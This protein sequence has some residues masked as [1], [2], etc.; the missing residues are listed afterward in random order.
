MS[1]SYPL[2]SP[3]SLPSHNT[4]HNL[5]DFSIPVHSAIPLNVISHHISELY[6]FNS[7]TLGVSL[8]ISMC[9][10]VS[11][12]IATVAGNM[13]PVFSTASC[14][15]FKPLRGLTLT[16]NWHG[17]QTATRWMAFAI[18][19]Q[20][21]NNM[22]A[23]N[24]E[25][26]EEGSSSSSSSSSSNSIWSLCSKATQW[27]W[28]VC[29]QMQTSSSHAPPSKCDIKPKKIAIEGHPAEI[30]YSTESRGNGC[31]QPMNDPDMTHIPAYVNCP[32]NL[33]FLSNH[34]SAAEKA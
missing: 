6:Q 30:W 28:S 18:V 21:S 33:S 5:N 24:A 25:W 9:L 19:F 27:K 15:C 13:Q 31:L 1:Y 4:I 22:L 23:G 10:R 20:L 7:H 26:R 2:P 3:P 32:Q 34:S 16:Q 12:F 11:V 17:I 14:C 8:C 29:L